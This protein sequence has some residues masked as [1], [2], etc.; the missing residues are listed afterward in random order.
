MKSIEVKHGDLTAMKVKH[1][2][3][4]ATPW[5]AQ[6]RNTS[7]MLHAKCCITDIGWTRKGACSV[8]PSSVK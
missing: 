3:R 7:Q 8:L 1:L 2:P 6:R 5:I 4:V